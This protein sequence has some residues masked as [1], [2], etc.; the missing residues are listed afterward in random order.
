MGLIHLLNEYILNEYIYIYSFLKEGHKE[1]N[2]GTSSESDIE[3]QIQGS[4]I[5]AEGV[6]SA[7][8]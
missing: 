4:D 3:T 8:I 1:E 7:Q 2:H 6:H 5:F